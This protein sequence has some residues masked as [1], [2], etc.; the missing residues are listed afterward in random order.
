MSGGDRIGVV[1]Q[2]RAVRR[3][4]LAQPRAAS[5]HDVGDAELAADL[6]QLA[7]RDDDLA[8]V[9]QRLE[10]Q[11]HRGGVVVDD[12]GVLG[13]GQPAQQRLHVAVARAA[14]LPGEVELEI[15]V[16]RARP[17]SS[18]SRASG[19]RSARPEV[20][21]EHDALRVDD[22]AQ[23]ERTAPAGA[24]S[25]TRSARSSAGRRRG[26]LGEDAGALLLERLAD[27]RPSGGPG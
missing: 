23:R 27:E 1:A 7:A 13:A 20:G 18:R 15:G 16:G 4:D 5:Q 25:T 6:D 14:L 22:R 21:V 3:A 8:A 9:G 2:V 12:E 26:P 24:R 11:Q 17:P 10:R 19:L